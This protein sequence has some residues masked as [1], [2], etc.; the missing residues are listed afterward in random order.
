MPLRT[1]LQAQRTK[2][3]VPLLKAAKRVILLTG[4]PALNKP[5]VGLLAGWL[6]GFRWLMASSSCHA[7]CPCGPNSTS[8][9]CCPL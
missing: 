8:S 7:P 3:T 1:P 9:G 4:T 2:A 5:K 6:A